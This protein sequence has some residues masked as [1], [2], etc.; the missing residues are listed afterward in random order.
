MIP[1]ASKDIFPLTFSRAWRYSSGHFPSLLITFFFSHAPLFSS[2]VF[3]F[4]GNNF[5]MWLS[6][7]HYKKKLLD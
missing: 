6:T 2:Y 5:L 1:A 3:L 7:G 4:W